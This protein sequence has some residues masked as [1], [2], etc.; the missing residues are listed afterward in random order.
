MDSSTTLASLLQRVMK[1]IPRQR[2]AATLEKWGRLP[3]EQLDFT[4]STRELTETLLDL[5]EV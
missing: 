5:C 2:L 1:R 4:M 3:L